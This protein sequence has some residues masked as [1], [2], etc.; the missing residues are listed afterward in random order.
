MSLHYPDPDH[1]DAEI[2]LNNGVAWRRYADGREEVLPEA[3]EDAWYERLHADTEAS[4]TRAR[5]GRNSS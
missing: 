4:L 3:D 2:I 1:A 5:S